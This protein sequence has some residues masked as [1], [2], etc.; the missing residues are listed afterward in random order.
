MHATRAHAHAH[1]PTPP[2]T[3]QHTT[4]AHNARPSKKTRPSLTPGLWTLAARRLDLDVHV[5][6]AHHAAPVPPAPNAAQAAQTAFDEL[7]L[8][9]N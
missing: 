4:C 1:T 2:S 9:T 6:A 5:V 8:A 3:P 7:C